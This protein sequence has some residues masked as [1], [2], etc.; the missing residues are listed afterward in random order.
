LRQ[1][2]LRRWQE[3]KKE[4]RVRR[5]L[6]TRGKKRVA[7][8]EA[9]GRRELKCR[10]EWR[11]RPGRSKERQAQRVAGRRMTAVSRAG[12]KGEREGIQNHN[13]I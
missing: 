3:A 1:R 5:Q 10:G 13:Q 2:M 9:E 4:E 7:N 12:M 11:E 6:G 8:R